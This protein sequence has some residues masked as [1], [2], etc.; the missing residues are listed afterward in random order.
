MQFKMGYSPSIERSKPT[1]ALHQAVLA[2]KMGFDS[3]WVDDHFLPVPH[4]TECG[5]AW[6]WMSSALQATDRVFFATAVT[7]P[8]MRY[9]PAVVAH[10][11]A[12]MGAMYPGRVGIGIGSGE[13][14]NEMAV[15]RGEWP[16]PGK[17]LDML[18]EALD[19]MHRLWMSTG[20]T[21]FDG[22]YYTLKNATMFTRPE[23][24][25]PVYFSA[26]GPRAS[27]MAGLLGDHLITV[28]KDPSVVRDVIIPNFEAGA[29]ESGK[30]PKTMERALAVL[31]FYDPDHVVDPEAMKVSASEA[32]I[33]VAGEGSQMELWHNA[34]DIIRRIEEWKRLGFDHIIFG[35]FSADCNAGLRVF[36]DVLP[37][38]V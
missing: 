5:F 8:I 28:A 20:P 23:G 38:V 29:K 19:V 4:M 25:I 18:S 32:K 24:P 9:N 10:A 21:S 7:A 15:V 1:E 6:T 27:K 12:T 31:Y 13:E 11:F 33:E 34:E 37:H 35:N 3:V 22:S 17:R 26:I 30:D 16:K 36:Q 14:L 2:E